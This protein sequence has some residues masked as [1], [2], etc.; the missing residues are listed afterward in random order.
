MKQMYDVHPTTYEEMLALRG[1]GRSTVR[2]LAF[3]SDLIYGASPSWKDPVR[4]SFTVGGKD[5]VPYP[6]DREA[7]DESAAM[8]RQG[9]EEAKIGDKQKI[10]ALRRLKEFLP[11][12]AS[13]S[14]IR[15]A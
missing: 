11:G 6:V 13:L 14:S 4:F 12:C 8:I 10:V 5:G 3:I 15:V 1:V 9:I 2:A 7:M